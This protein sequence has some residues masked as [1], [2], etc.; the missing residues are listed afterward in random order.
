MSVVIDIEISSVEAR[1]P[2]NAEESGGCW[3][4]WTEAGLASG[5]AKTTVSLW[6]GGNREDHARYLQAL[7][8]CIR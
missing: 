1:S 3:C 4:A 8:A 2:E 5:V 7:G 6:P